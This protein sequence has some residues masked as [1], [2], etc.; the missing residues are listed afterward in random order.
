MG[1]ELQKIIDSIHVVMKVTK[2]AYDKALEEGF[3]PNQ[4]LDISGRYM[5]KFIDIA[6]KK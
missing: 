1:E 3:L 4:A 2:I 6:T 5:E